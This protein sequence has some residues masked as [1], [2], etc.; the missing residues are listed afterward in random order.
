[1][2]ARRCRHALIAA[3]MALV[4]GGCAL[5]SNVADVAPGTPQAAVLATYG[6]P[7]ARYP[8]TATEGARWQYSL[9]PSGQ[10]VYNVDFDAAGR[11]VH[12]EQALNEGLFGQRIKVGHW[13]RADV[14]REYGPPARTMEVHNFNGIIW[15]YRYTNGPTWR[16]LYIDIDPAGIVQSYS[17][18]DQNLPDLMDSR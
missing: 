11:V 16:L 3:L 1:M 13:T 12:A 5:F 4:L 7:T 18:G 10:A 14:L 2:T 6:Q 8:A 17:E 15:V 9:E